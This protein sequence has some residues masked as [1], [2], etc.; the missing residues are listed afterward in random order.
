MMTKIEIKPIP[1]II[2]VD[3]S[4]I[5]IHIRLPLINFHVADLI[6]R[7]VRPIRVIAP[8]RTNVASAR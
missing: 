2:P 5:C 1:S 8:A 4:V 6:G 3:M 7:I